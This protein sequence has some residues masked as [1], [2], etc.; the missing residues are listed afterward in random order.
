MHPATRACPDANPCLCRGS[1]LRHDRGL[2]VLHPF[3]AGPRTPRVL[4]RRRS[5]TRGFI[6]RR[7]LVAAGVLAL[8][9]ASSGLAF[10]QNLPKAAVRNVEEEFF[11]T[12]VTDPYRYF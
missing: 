10:G 4:C 12:K 11:G 6:S 2:V 8:A 5:M 1:R 7:R 3:A 9:A